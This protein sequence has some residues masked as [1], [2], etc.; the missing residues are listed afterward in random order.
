MAKLMIY[1][2]I[3]ENYAYTQEGGYCTNPG[4]WKPKGSGE[5]VVLNVDVNKIS[6][7]V[8]TASKTIYADNEAFRESVT[9]WEV[10]EDDYLTWF[11]KSQLEYD[12]KIMF[13]ATVI[14]V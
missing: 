13:P 3:F 1:T 4:F 9:S 14:S 7:I 6:E 8:E 12:G 5:Y 11:E 2:Q 10:V